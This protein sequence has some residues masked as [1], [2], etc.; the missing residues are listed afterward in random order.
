MR[1]FLTPRSESEI[2]FFRIP[3]LG[4]PTKH[5]WDSISLIE[6]TWILCK[7]API[8]FLPLFKNQIIFNFVK[9]MAT[10][11]VGEQPFSPPLFIVIGSGIRA[12]HPGSAILGLAI[13]AHLSEE[14]ILSQT[15]VSS[16]SMVRSIS[17]SAKCTNHLSWAFNSRNWFFRS[18]SKSGPDVHADETTV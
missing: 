12:K 15:W 8:F 2:S 11:K 9:F 13:R 14:E 7:F 16:S 6:N 1:Y 5:F 10:K 18:T 17:F 4:F 3:D